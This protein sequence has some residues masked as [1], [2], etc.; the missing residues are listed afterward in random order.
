M[1]TKNFYWVRE[2]ENYQISD[3]EIRI[4]TQAH[5]DLWQR[6]YYHFVNDNAPLLLM[7]TEE[8]YFSFTVKT[9][10]SNSHTRFDQ[11]GVVVYQDSENWIKGSI[12]YENE[13]FQHLG[14]VVTNHGFS[15]WATQ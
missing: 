15:D 2:P 4:T 3:K 11:C 6:T 9:D 12:E 7:D 14:S 10:F 5:T 8:E 13:D 1:N